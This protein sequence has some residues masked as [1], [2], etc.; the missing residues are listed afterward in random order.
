MTVYVDDMRARHGQHILC[1][2]IADSE[3]ELHAMAERIGMERRRYQ[4]DHYD[5]PLA[6]KG[7]ALAAGAREIRQR[8]L[9]CMVWLKRHGHGM[10]EPETAEVRYRS[11]RS[12]GSGSEALAAGP[13]APGSA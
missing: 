6:Q 10:G 11:C 12:A 7:L 4:G 1:H 8:Q 2:M 9:A 13:V 3:E 5:I